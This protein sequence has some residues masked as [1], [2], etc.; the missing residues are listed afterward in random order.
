[1]TQSVMNKREREAKDIAYLELQG[2]LEGLVRFLAVVLP[3]KLLEPL[4][5]GESL[6]KSSITFKIIGLIENFTNSAFLLCDIASLNSNQRG[7]N[8]CIYSS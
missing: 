2:H 5:G 7:Q 1:M 4:I 6:K 8:I 3:L